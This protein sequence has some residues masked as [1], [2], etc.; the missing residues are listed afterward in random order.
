MLQEAAASATAVCRLQSKNKRLAE[1]LN[2]KKGHHEA[3]EKL[4]AERR[5][6]KNKTR[7]LRDTERLNAPWV[8]SKSA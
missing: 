8:V 3:A 7:I 6:K 2:K 5:Q 4:S 1:Q